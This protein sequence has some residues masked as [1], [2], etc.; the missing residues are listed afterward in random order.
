M[1]KFV[2]PLDNVLKFKERMADHE[3]DILNRMRFQLHKIELEIAALQEKYSLS[4][5]SFAKKS[6]VGITVPEMLVCYSYLKE[7]ETEIEKKDLCRQAAELE[8]A[9]QMK[10][11]IGLTQEQKS[12]ETLKDKQFERYQAQV[13]K[14]E[15][16]FIEEFVANGQIR[17][18]GNGLQAG[19]K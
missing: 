4:K 1:K 6:A 11:L 3:K 18:E 16:I 2:F 8:I 17:D 19:L 15:E 10:I 7:L 13:M 12:M 9:G 14:A 5:L